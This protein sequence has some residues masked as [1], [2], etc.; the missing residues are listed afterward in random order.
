MTYILI[1]LSLSAAALAL[2]ISYYKSAAG[3]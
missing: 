1:G 3:K 2:Q